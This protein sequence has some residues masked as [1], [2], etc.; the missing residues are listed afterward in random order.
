MSGP[1]CE[2]GC[3]VFTGG[4]R[5]HHRDCPYYPESMTK[6]WHDTEA[7]YVAEIERLRT[8]LA[9]ETVWQSMDIAPTDGTPFVALE[10]NEGSK[11]V[12]AR[13]Y[14]YVGHPNYWH[15]KR[16]GVCIR[17]QYQDRFVWAHLPAD[18]ESRILSAL[19]TP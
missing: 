4:E 11:E 6:L 17:P 7:D 1:Q 3:M 12:Y 5:K 8:S 15:C 18:Y 2:A 9:L 13:V 16:H 19:V 10:I 14:R